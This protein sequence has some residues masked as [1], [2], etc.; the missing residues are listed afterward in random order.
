MKNTTIV[1]KTAN[2]RFGHSLAS[3][4]DLNNDGFEGQFLMIFSLVEIHNI[5][6]I[7]TLLL[8]HPMRMEGQCMCTMVR[9]AV[10]II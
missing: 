2:G 8:A 1:G 9:T 7:Q 4:G 5:L 6:S 10:M 3:L